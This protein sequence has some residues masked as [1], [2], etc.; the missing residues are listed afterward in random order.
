M[1][2]SISLISSKG[3]EGKSVT[4]TGATQHIISPLPGKLFMQSTIAAE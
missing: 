1:P 3:I 4:G 2:K